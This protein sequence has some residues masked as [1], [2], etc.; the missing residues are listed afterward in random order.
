MDKEL[1]CH[2]CGEMT[3]LK[4][5]YDEIDVTKIKYCPYCGSDNIEVE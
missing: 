3:V 4:D 1:N 2:D 5:E